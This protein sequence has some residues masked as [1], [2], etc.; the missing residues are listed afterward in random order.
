M[1]SLT[2]QWLHY[3][4][5]SYNILFTLFYCLQ[6]HGH[7]KADNNS[8]VHAAVSFYT[9]IL[10][11]SIQQ[12][13]PVKESFVAQIT[14]FLLKGVRSRNDEFKCSSYMILSTLCSKVRVHY[15]NL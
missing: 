15:P 1:L 10:L 3:L 4:L 11:N 9:K 12:A 7:E 8:P 2:L 5:V 13:D 14:T 6:V